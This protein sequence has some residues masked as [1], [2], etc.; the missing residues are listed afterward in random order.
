MAY[1]QLNPPF[2][3]MTIIPP[4]H[5]LAL[6]RPDTNTGRP[7]GTVD[8]TTLAAHDF[9][10]DTR[11]GF[12]PPDPPVTRLPSQWE[13]WEAA[14]DEAIDNKLQLGDRAGLSEEDRRNASSWQAHVR[15]VVICIF[16]HK[17][18]SQACLDASHFYDRAQ[19]LGSTSS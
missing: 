4:D 7:E 5:F 18:L 9:D 1:Q 14:L 8:T 12:M 2:D 16:H 3:F 17:P 6:P 15:Q 10:V 11:S 13:A 19:N